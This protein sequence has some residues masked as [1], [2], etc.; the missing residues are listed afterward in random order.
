[1]KIRTLFIT[2]ASVVAL[3]ST[4]MADDHLVNAE[5]HGLKAGS[6]GAIQGDH[7]E[8]QGSWFTGKDVVTPASGANEDF[9]NLNTTDHCLD[10]KNPH[11]PLP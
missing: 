5:N 1:M 2:A 9:P 7:G 10:P 6:T 3:S 4:G 8:G 11:C